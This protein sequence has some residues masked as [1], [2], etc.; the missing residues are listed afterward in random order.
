M[1]T[2]HAPA[3]AEEIRMHRRPTATMLGTIDAG[4]ARC[5]GDRT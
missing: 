5:G 3:E 2:L 1:L 4:T